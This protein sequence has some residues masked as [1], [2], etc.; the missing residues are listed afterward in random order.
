MCFYDQFEYACK[1]F[2]WGNFREHCN[3]EYRRGETCGM[4][5]VHS[6]IEKSDVCSI[7]EKINRKIRR[8]YNYEEKL[9][10]WEAEGRLAELSATVERYRAEQMEVRMEIDRLQGE[11]EERA[12]AIGRFPKGSGYAAAQSYGT[13][14]ASVNGYPTANGYGGGYGNGY[15]AYGYNHYAG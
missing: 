10:T 11:R 15:A 14:Y 6:V 7:C 1:D 3:K 5:L 2:R 4:K 9:K 13:G 12:K 8:W